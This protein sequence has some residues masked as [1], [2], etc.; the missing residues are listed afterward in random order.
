MTSVADMLSAI[1]YINFH[2]I[3]DVLQFFKRYHH[4]QYFARYA[5]LFERS[6]VLLF[7]N[8]EIS[9]ILRLVGPFKQNRIA[10]LEWSGFWLEPSPSVT[11]RPLTTRL[12]FRRKISFKFVWT[13]NNAV[14]WRGQKKNHR[15][16]SRTLTAIYTAPQTIM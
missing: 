7:Q 2:R 15:W 14:L 10:I 16:G 1:R 3:T 4:C 5:N 13:R 11:S 6:S 8:T 12:S 9:P